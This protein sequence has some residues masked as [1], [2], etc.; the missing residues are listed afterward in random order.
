MDAL[1]GNSP[2]PR[3][4]FFYFNDDGPLVAL[5]YNQWKIVFAEQRRPSLE[6]GNLLFSAVRGLASLL[7][8]P[9]FSGE[10]AGSGCLPDRG[11]QRGKGGDR[12]DCL[13]ASSDQLALAASFLLS[14]HV[15]PPL[16]D[17]NLL[18][19]ACAPMVSHVPPVTVYPSARKSSVRSFSICAAASNGIGFRCS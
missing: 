10:R 8:R 3:H 11:D 16:F 6:T 17:Q 15:T 1:A 19:R 12:N 5:S 9:H 4:E 7:R 2:S 13:S 14:R 18:P